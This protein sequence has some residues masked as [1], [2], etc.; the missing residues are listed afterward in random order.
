LKEVSGEEDKKTPVSDSTHTGSLK[1]VKK[2][3]TKEGIKEAVKKGKRSQK[4]PEE[5]KISTS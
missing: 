3:A 5:S 4:K 2:R 1:P